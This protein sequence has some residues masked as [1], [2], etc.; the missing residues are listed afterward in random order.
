MYAC[1]Q[2]AEAT[3]KIRFPEFRPIELE[4][5]E[6]L[7]S[8]IKQYQPVSCE[9]NFANLFAW[10][11]K[12]QT[13]WTT[14]HNRLLIYDGVAKVFFMPLGKPFNTKELVLL[15]MQVE[16][17]GFPAAFSLCQKAQIDGHPEL[18]DYFEIENNPAIAEY[19]YDVDALI[20]LKGT[21][22]HKKKNLIAQFKRQYPDF[23]VRPLTPPLRKK[24]FELA[25]Q[26]YQGYENPPFSLEHE[27]SAITASF[28]HFDELKL[29]G[30]AIQVGDEL[31]AF[32]V[33]SRL[34]SQTFDVQ[35]EKSNTRYKGAAQVVNQET[36]K[37]LADHCKL[38]NREQ[39]LG[40][41]GLRQAKMSYDP[42][43]VVPFYTLRYRSEA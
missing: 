8:Y 13:L 34:N 2:N 6:C 7:K 26:L 33:F 14:Y 31:V 12:Y 38:I 1:E 30:I 18:A 20:Q 29:N 23:E 21:K 17:A 16:Q 27:F 4:D 35:F 24:A 11:E 19:I 43:E 36:A 37:F 41:K 28:K 10:Q 15:S 32:S 42:L 3:E 9:Y 5:R 39:D 22:L 40:L 25:Q